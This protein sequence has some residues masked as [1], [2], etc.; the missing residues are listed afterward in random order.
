MREVGEKQWTAIVLSSLGLIALYQGNH[1]RASALCEESLALF[2]DSGD[3]RGIASVLTN[4]GMMRLADVLYPI[5]KD[6]LQR[7]RE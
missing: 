5:L 1:E 7:V 4:L 3:I 2:R 6:I